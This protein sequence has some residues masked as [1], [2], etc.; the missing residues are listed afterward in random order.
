MAGRVDLTLDFFC[1][2]FSLLKM[3]FFLLYVVLLVC[4]FGEVFL[5]HECIYTVQH[6]IGNAFY[7][8]PTSHSCVCVFIHVCVYILCICVYV[9]ILS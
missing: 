6:E 2:I 9:C 5:N 3:F 7:V 8:L 1:R 4:I